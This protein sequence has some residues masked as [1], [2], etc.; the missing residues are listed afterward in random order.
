MRHEAQPRIVLLLLTL[1]SAIL[2]LVATVWA[3]LSDATIEYTSNGRSVTVSFSEEDLR[4]VDRDPSFVL[5][6]LRQSGVKC[7]APRKKISKCI[8]EC[9]DGSQTRTCNS[10][11][12]KALDTLWEK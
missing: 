3:Q 9:C 1:I 7:C 6:N 8:W 12:L 2:I 11:L 5:T 4:T 10:T